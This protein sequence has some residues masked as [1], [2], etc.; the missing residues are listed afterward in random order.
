M[1]IGVVVPT[2]VGH[3][4]PMSTLCRELQRRGH[5]VKVISFPDSSEKIQQAGLEHVVIGS[6][7]FPLGEWEFMTRKL[8]VQSG[9]RAAKFTIN[10]LGAISTAVLEDLPGVLNS[11][12][13]DGLIMDQVCYGA[14]NVANDAGL[15]LV[16]ACNALPVHFQPD[17]P[18]HSETWPWR[19]DP[20]SLLRNR[21]M[22]FA[23]IQLARSFWVPIRNRELA[24][25]RGWNVWDYLNEIPPS[26]AQIAQ[27]PA[28]LDF[29]RQHA[30]DH[31]HHTGPWHESVSAKGTGFDW[32]WLDG[33]PLIYASLGTLQNGLDHLYRIMLDACA[34]LPMQIVVALGRANGTV[35]G[36]IPAN[37]KVVG[38]APQLSLLKRSSLVITHAGLNTTLESLAQGL[39]MVALPITNEQPGIAARIRHAG[40]G[41]WLSLRGLS[42]DK[43]RKM[44]LKVYHDPSYRARA[45]KCA[46]LLAGESGLRRAA[47]IV[48]EAFASRRKV[49]RAPQLK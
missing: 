23:I 28:C 8:S 19:T 33:Q 39:P 9:L 4:N 27:L 32:E 38:Y 14:E 10:W 17:I 16:V 34:P 30:P 12:R 47:D 22:Q 49:L 7:R 26:L 41:E 6:G 45:R 46:G 31:F 3:L 11:E 15:P 24:S 25:G 20:L 5:R 18:V 44:V 42:P 1:N 43:L 21:I 36:T 13:H 48:E 35:S 29:P 2:W 40:V 37:A